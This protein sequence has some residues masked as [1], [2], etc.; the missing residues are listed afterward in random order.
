MNIYLISEYV[1][2]MQ[3][4]DVN[5]LALKQG[6]TLDNEELDIIY[7]YIKN[8]YKTLIY[9]NPKVILEEIK[10]QVK[11]LTYNKIE[12]LYMQFKDKIDNF[13]KNIKGY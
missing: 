4:Q 11:P 8:N 6:I 9:G 2:R 12:N 1:N 7:N 13:T 5:N 10:Y 3:K